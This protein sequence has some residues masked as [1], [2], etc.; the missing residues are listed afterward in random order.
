M[1][2]QFTNIFTNYIFHL[3]IFDPFFLYN[4]NGF[5]DNSYKIILAIII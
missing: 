4:N 3:C 1:F 2:L 5:S